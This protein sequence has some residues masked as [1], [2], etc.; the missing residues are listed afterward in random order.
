MK[1]RLFILIFFSLGF[2]GCAI[3][4]PNSIR[5]KV[6]PGMTQEEVAAS[7]NDCAYVFKCPKVSTHSV[8]GSSDVYKCC[9]TYFDFDNG[10]LQRFTIFDY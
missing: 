2:C 7:W 4:G 6:Y 5:H 10:K 1:K 8:W 3:I 9:K